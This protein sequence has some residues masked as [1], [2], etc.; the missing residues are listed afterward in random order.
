MPG[1]KFLLVL[2]AAGPSPFGGRN[3]ECSAADVFAATLATTLVLAGMVL[4]ELALRWFG[5]PVTAR[6]SSIRE[7]DSPLQGGYEHVAR[8]TYASPG[9][10]AREDELLISWRVDR[11]GS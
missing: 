7:Q 2:V 8:Y 10:P 3:Q 6:V 1:Q 9:R 4:N 5:H 11:R